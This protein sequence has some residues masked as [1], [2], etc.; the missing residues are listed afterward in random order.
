MHSRGYDVWALRGLPLTDETR[1]DRQKRLTQL[2]SKVDE[3]AEGSMLYYCVHQHNEEL[4]Y[5]RKR[6]FTATAKL[7]IHNDEYDCMTKGMDDD[8]MADHDADVDDDNEDLDRLDFIEE[9]EKGRD[10][11][12][13]VAFCG[14]QGSIPIVDLLRKSVSV[15]RN[16][17]VR[18][19]KR[20]REYR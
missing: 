15:R 14:I 12:I 4:N 19:R 11:D 16:L 7:E 5:S 20:E 13:G 1:E 17:Q 3:T 6:R 2:K 8:Y 10:E 18:G 9:D